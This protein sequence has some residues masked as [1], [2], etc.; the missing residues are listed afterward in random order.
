MFSKKIDG[1][2]ECE[3][4][5]HY[6]NLQYNLKKFKRVHVN[7]SYVILFFG[8]DGYIYFVDYEHHNNIYKH[9]KKALKKYEDLKFK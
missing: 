6:K 8:D 4:I 2:L 3:E 7:D 9:S 1:I 5:D